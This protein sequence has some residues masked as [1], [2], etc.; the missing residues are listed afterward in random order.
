ML[1]IP[2]PDFESQKKTPHGA[3]HQRN[4]ANATT[5]VSPSTL[6]VE[7]PATFWVTYPSA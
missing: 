1:H 3:E 6:L 7:L 4:V 2:R 5:E